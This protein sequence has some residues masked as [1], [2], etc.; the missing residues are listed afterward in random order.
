M[1]AA[2]VLG[3]SGVKNSGK[4]TLISKLIPA[5][6]RKGY[7]LAVLKHDGHSYDPEPQG[8]DTHAYYK[9]GASSWAIYDGEKFS[10]NQKRKMT[11]EDLLPF[12]K[13][14]DLV[15]IEGLKGSDY[16]KLE[17]MRKINGRDPVCKEETVLAYVV[18]FPYEGTKTSFK[19]H[20]I[21]ELTDFIIERLLK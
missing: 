11:S 20:E 2:K 4:T 19:F 15:L 7:E 1:N 13:G 17:L 12:F 8:T 3:I 21:E 9:A 6:Q 5:F 16:P 10:F 14:A 18:D